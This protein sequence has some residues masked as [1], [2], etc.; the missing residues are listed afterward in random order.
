[1][2][3]VA[4]VLGGT[5]VNGGRGSIGGS[6]IGVM[7]MAV[8]AEGLRAGGSVLWMEEK[9]PFKFNNLRFVLLG[10]LLLIGVWMDGLFGPR[11]DSTNDR[12]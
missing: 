3:I 4:V 1:M 5:S 7:L 11:D 2:V 6:V 10:G 8:L 9:L 12:S